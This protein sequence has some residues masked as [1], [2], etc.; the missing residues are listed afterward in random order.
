MLDSNV[1]RDTIA[2]LRADGW[3][4]ERDLFSAVAPYQI[5]TVVETLQVLALAGNIRAAGEDDKKWTG[6]N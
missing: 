4:Y 2:R 6:K 5:G 1:V 3:H